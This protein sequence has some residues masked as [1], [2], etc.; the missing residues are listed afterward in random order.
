M[1]Y[2]KD[3]LYHFNP[4]HDPKDGK[5]TFAKGV[6]KIKG[7]ANKIMRWIDA[8]DELDAVMAKKEAAKR[9]EKNSSESVR[10]STH[11]E[12]LKDLTEME[13][14]LENKSEPING[15]EVKDVLTTFCGFTRKDFGN[16]YGFDT[17][18]FSKKIP[19]KDASG[20]NVSL[21]I[22]IDHSSPMFKSGTSKEKLLSD[23]SKI[24]KNWPVID[25]NI[26]EQLSSEIA[27]E[28]T[29]V[30]DENPNSPPLTAKEIANRIGK[31]AAG[32]TTS[33]TVSYDPSSTESGNYGEVYY[34]DGGLFYGHV[35]TVEY[36][37][38]KD[39]IRQWM[40]EG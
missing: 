5:F 39:K 22:S 6:R 35:F 34:S 12:E 28:G 40:V 24:E 15:D 21:D 8:Q 25:K 11:E 14:S 16:N 30:D 1:Q 36:D 38:D 4:N 31:D 3:E 29:W 26:K 17:T 23:L 32:K 7:A 20:E 9:G 10:P 27:K 33:P 13:K 18:F 37:F 19:V 2:R